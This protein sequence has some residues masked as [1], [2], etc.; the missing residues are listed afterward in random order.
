[1]HLL[2]Y[3]VAAFSLLVCFWFIKF[4]FVVFAT[5][6]VVKKKNNLFGSLFF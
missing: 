4:L 6:L 5:T 1:M 3:L 2:L